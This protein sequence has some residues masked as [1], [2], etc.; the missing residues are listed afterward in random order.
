MVF[1]K[2]KLFSLTQRK[3]AGV[4][5]AP[6][7]GLF[8]HMM[9][10]YWRCF[11]FDPSTI[12]ILSRKSIW[13]QGDSPSNALESGWRWTLFPGEI[14]LS[15]CSRQSSQTFSIC[16]ILQPIAS[17]SAANDR[18]SLRLASTYEIIPNLSNIPG[19]IFF[20][21]CICMWIR[22]FENLFTGCQ[23][24]DVRKVLSDSLWI[25]FVH[26]KVPETTR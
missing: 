11:L 19:F 17:H 1:D 25:H 7:I 20:I 15:I 6:K 12:G 23:R 13:F 9:H 16:P 24:L 14:V 26:T 22:D 8:L 18:G 21:L 4:C 10:R 2:A 5:T 3:F